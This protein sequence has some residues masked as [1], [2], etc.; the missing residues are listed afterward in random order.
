MNKHLFDL[1]MLFASKSGAVLV[2]IIFLPWYHQLLGESLFGIVAVILSLQALLI[3]LDLGMATIVAR[4]IAARDS[5]G[6][7][8]DVVSLFRQS[9]MLLTVFYVLLFVLSIVFFYMFQ[10]SLL[11]EADVLYIILLFFTLVMQNVGQ[12]ALIAV[13]SY[14]VASS[15]QLVGV[16]LRALVTILALKYI[17]ASLTVFVLAQLSVSVAHWL[18]TRLLCHSLLLPFSGNNKNPISMGSVWCLLKRGRPLL[19]AGVAGAAVMQLDKPIILYFMSA[20]DVGVYFLAMSFS[21]LPLFVLAAPV[22]QFFQPRIVEAITEKDV[23]NTKRLL[24]LLFLALLF[25]VGLPTLIIGLF[26]DSVL[27]LW[28]QDSVLVSQVSSYVGILLFGALAGAFGYIP[29]IVLIAQE[30]YR[31]QAIV[32]WCLTIITLVLVVWF[33]GV[34]DI[35]GI[36]WTYFFY[37]VSTVVVFSCRS[38]N[39]R[40]STI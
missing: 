14:V 32:S 6:G 23:L 22:A 25:F 26:K 21:M 31:Y 35:D 8:T 13:K 3:M 11:H 24:W 30:D 33:S 38:W 12:S 1:G 16:L 27:L 5:L 4:D 34:A 15:I 19:L 40:I 2:G 36:C 17:E 7:T 39:K 37:H 10:P 28:L 29:Y 9:E 20:S 18:V